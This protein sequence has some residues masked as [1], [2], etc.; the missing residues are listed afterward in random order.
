[1]GA[2]RHQR[3]EVPERVVGARGLRDL[4]VRLGLDGMDQVGKLDRVLDKKHRDVVAHQVVV[5][6]MG[7]ELDRKAARVAHGVGGAA[8]AGH[9][10]EAREN[11]RPDRG[12]GQ[13]AG[14]G[15]FRARLVHLKV[16]MRTGTSRMDGP[17][18]NPFM[19]KMRN[20]LAQ[21]EI[22]Q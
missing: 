5:A 22:F 21:Y 16:A 1:M 2:L 10:R 11:R 8:R 17:F 13:K 18:W 19:V 4:V 7:V 3:R 15:Q 12:V 9:G 6:L 14:A 20:L